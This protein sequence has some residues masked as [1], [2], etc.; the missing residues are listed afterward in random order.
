MSSLNRANDAIDELQNDTQKTKKSTEVLIEI[1]DLNDD[2]LVHIFS[3]LKLPNLL[4]IADTCSR[5][6]QVIRTMHKCKQATKSVKINSLPKSITYNLKLLR[7]FGDQIQTLLIN[8]FG[9]YDTKSESSSQIMVAV[10]QYIY[11]YCL[12]SESL[13]ELRLFYLPKDAFESIEK[14]FKSVKAVYFYYGFLGEKISQFNRYFPKLISL[15]IGEIS[16]AENTSCIETKLPFLQRLC[17]NTTENKRFFS[18]KSIERAISL[19]SQ[20]II[21]YYNCK[22][23]VWVIKISQY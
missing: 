10:E 16:G 2:C 4:N 23:Q 8:Y 22:Q 6:K 12:E 1:T 7:N 9:I 17:V 21:I 5:F 11:K 3:F 14:P 20:L 13:N 18:T 15:E 19:N